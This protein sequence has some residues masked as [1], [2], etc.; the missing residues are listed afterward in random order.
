[1]PYSLA[2]AY[3]PQRQALLIE[4]FNAKDI[5]MDIVQIAVSSG[6]VVG[7]GGAGGDI[8]TD[9]LF[10]MEL[11]NDVLAEVQSIIGEMA[12]LGSIISSAASLDFAGN[13]DA[14][15]EEVQGLVKRT[16]ASE[17]AGDKAKDFIKK[18]ATTVQKVINK[19]VRAISKWVAALLPD[20]FG[21]SGPAF[22][23]TMSSAISAGAG[24]AYNLAVG[25]VE[26]LGETGK[27]LT[28][29]A[30]LEDF[31]HK[32]VE[33]IITAA[34][35]MQD[36]LANPEG[37]GE[38][39][40][41]F[42][43]KVASFHPA[44]QLAK[45]ATG[46]KEVIPKVIFILEEMRDAWIPQTAAVLHKLISWLFAAIAIFQMIMDP[47]QR[48]ELLDIETRESGFDPLG[49]EDMDLDI[50]F[51]EEDLDMRRLAAHYSPRKEKLLREYVRLRLTNDL[52]F[53]QM[54]EEEAV[55]A[56]E[57]GL[58][59]SDGVVAV[60][61]FL[62]SE[63]G[64]DPKVRELLAQGDPKNET[65]KVSDTDKGV[66]EL[67]PT[68]NE[69]SLSNSIGYPL[70]SLDSLH[71]VKSGDPTGGKK[72]DS[73]NKTARRIVTADDLVI[74]GHHRWSSVYAIAGDAGSIKVKNIAL[75]GKSADEKLAAA[76]VGVVAT[77]GQG[78]VP[79]AAGSGLPDNILGTNAAGIKS[80]ILGMVDEKM[81][82]GMPLLSD[83]YVEEA[84]ADSEAQG[85]FGI[86]E[87]MSVEDAREAIAG[88]VA[89]NL[90]AL[91][92]PQGPEREHMPQFGIST[93]EE[94]VFNKMSSGQVNWQ[95]DFSPTSTKKE[96]LRKKSEDQMIMERWQKLAGLLKG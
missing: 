32:I 73:G 26:A 77:M 76:Q 80:M 11:A 78:K 85:Y 83:E 12:E 49:I 29:S 20:D 36:M 44:V 66:T 28:D 33:S 21:L 65:I 27:L 70:S 74:D 2:T 91:P 43:T 30:A 67:N 37:F 63:E 15:Y 56:L 13:H 25:G 16:V 64:S 34:K 69:I 4:G 24:D 51:S 50:D 62:N 79:S 89:A 96:S 35:D 94:D 5:T 61:E 58:D 54:S 3:Y 10:A 53:E 93:S 82:N 9:A 6:A 75:P 45:A 47:E 7:T 41:S 87:D 81:D 23:V 1:M 40:V 52:L 72:D 59:I 14:F 46:T 60:K 19:L 48:K 42:M 86:S 22:E 8:I 57:Q 31:L 88:A 17:F 71:N 68:Q 55:E 95:K 92:G 38:K 84:K 90:A 39:Y 18:V